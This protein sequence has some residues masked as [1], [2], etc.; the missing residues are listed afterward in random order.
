MATEAFEEFVHI[1]SEVTAPQE[2]RRIAAHVSECYAGSSIYFPRRPV[3]DRR[4]AEVR[5]AHRAGVSVN[6]LARR[7]R[8]SSSSIRRILAASS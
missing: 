2:A 7:H 4:D 6:D 1:L 5:A 8:L 3:L